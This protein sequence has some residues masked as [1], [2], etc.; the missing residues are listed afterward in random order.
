M[1]G[2]IDHEVCHEYD[3]LRPTQNLIIITYQIIWISWEVTQFS[4]LGSRGCCTTHYLFKRSQTSRQFFLGPM[5]RWWYGFSTATSESK[6]MPE[7]L[8]VYY[9]TSI[10][11]IGQ[12]IFLLHSSHL[13]PATIPQ[14]PR[15]SM[16]PCPAGS[17]SGSSRIRL[18]WLHDHR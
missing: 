11:Q 3:M 7:S 15:R 5:N 14:W 13:P 1:A 6:L 18:K 2:I 9:I 8:S 12:E 10:W 4:L 17:S 16:G